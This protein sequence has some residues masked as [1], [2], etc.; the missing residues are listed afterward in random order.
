MRPE[1]ATARPRMKSQTNT[2]PMSPWMSR[3]PLVHQ[4]VEKTR[5][6]GPCHLLI[7]TKPTQTYRSPRMCVTNTWPRTKRSMAKKNQTS[8]PCNPGLEQRQHWLNGYHHEQQQRRA[9]RASQDQERATNKAL[10]EKQ[11]W[12]VARTQRYKGGHQ[13]HSG[14]HTLTMYS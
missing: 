8:F 12:G 2:P 3:R 13:N 5:Q 7:P 10:L 4:G 9:H 1:K 6:K 11:D 14:T